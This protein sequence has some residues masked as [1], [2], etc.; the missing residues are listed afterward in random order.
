MKK[1]FTVLIISLTFTVYAQINPDYK[2]LCQWAQEYAFDCNYARALDCYY[3]AVEESPHNASAAMKSFFELTAAY[4]RQELEGLSEIYAAADP[5]GRIKKTNLIWLNEFK[6]WKYYIKVS[7]LKKG[8]YNPE[9]KKFAYS[10]DYRVLRDGNTKVNYV[11]KA[12]NIENNQIWYVPVFTVKTPDGKK[13]EIDGFNVYVS[14]EDCPAI[15]NKSVR[16]GIT[17][18][19][20]FYDQPYGSQVAQGKKIEPEKLSFKNWDFE[21]DMSDNAIDKSQN[22]MEKNKTYTFARLK[23]LLQ[24]K[25]FTLFE[26]ELK[27]NKCGIVFEDFG[28]PLL[29]YECVKYN[30]ILSVATLGLEND[31]PAEKYGLYGISPQKDGDG[32]KIRYYTKGAEPKSLKAEDVK[33]YKIFKNHE[34]YPDEY[35]L[36]S[37]LNWY[38]E[39]TDTN[40]NKTYLCVEPVVHKR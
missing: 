4:D 26:K 28:I 17:G 6:D 35:Y 25:E 40:G 2:R 5:L 14:P 19:Y 9:K 32:E 27:D 31:I 30:L 38:L 11:Q 20:E 8:A 15:D 16:F 29:I 13:L 33:I 24:A 7:P 39:K 37:D 22:L 18:L 23:M 12:L 3:S 10:F 34:A 21:I 1:L 36:G